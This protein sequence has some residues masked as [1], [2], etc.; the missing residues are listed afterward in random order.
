MQVPASPGARLGSLPT[1]AASMQTG[2]LEA[3]QH[4]LQQL[5][6]M[7]SSRSSSSDFQADR[8]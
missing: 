3:E 7:P 8:R 4:P 1:A 6:D 2:A 5:A